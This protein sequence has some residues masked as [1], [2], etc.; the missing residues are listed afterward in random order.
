[1]SYYVLTNIVYEIE[2]K[3]RVGHLFTDCN[4]SVEQPKS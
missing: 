3:K 1:M 2:G 4:I